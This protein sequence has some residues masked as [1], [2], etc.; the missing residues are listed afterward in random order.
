MPTSF[1]SLP[2]GGRLSRSPRPSRQSYCEWKGRASYYAFTTPGPSK[3]RVEN[4]IFDYPD[5]DGTNGKY[6]AVKGYLSFYATSD[7]DEKTQGAWKAYI[8][9]ELVKPQPGG[10]YSG[11]VD[12]YVEGKVKGAPGTWGW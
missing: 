8:D 10:F 1:D 3:T 9:D 7:T 12:Q 6:G 5:A 11:W 4:R 2:R